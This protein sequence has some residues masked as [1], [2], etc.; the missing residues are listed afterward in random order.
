MYRASTASEFIS[1]Q[2]YCVSS[3][4]FWMMLLK[5]SY[6]EPARLRVCVPK[7][8]KRPPTD[9][10]R[11]SCSLPCCGSLSSHLHPVK[12]RFELYHHTKKMAKTR[13]QST[14]KCHQTMTTVPGSLVLITLP[15]LRLLLLL[16]TALTKNRN[17]IR[18]EEKST[19]FSFPD[20]GILE[21]NFGT[22][23]WFSFPQINDTQH[24]THTGRG[25]FCV[26]DNAKMCNKR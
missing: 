17:Y 9:H 6:P 11:D 13:I 19:V 2:L 5:C 15:V 10:T 1:D 20:N 24:S 26:K 7:K 4:R 18:T 8:Q 23:R 22:R 3:V 21:I 14:N 25:L 12:V 16:Q